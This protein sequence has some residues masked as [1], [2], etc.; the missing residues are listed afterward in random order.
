MKNSYFLFLLISLV[1]FSCQSPEPSNTTPESTDLQQL[2]KF[3]YPIDDLE[4]GMVYEY[5][6]EKTGSVVGYWHYSTVK[7]EAGNRYLIGTNYNPFFEQ[8]QFSREWIVATGTILK[9]YQFIQTDSATGKAIMRPAKIEESV[10]Y[11][12][13]ALSDSSLAYRFRMKFSLLPDTTTHYDLVRDRKFGKYMNY[14]YDGK[15]RKAVMF[16]TKEYIDAH[17]PVEGGS[18][19]LNS[20]MTEIFAAGIGLVYTKKTSQGVNYTHRLKRRFTMEEFIKMKES[21]IQN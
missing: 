11:P 18:W 2:K 3:Y 12:F 4:D 19:Q 20:D 21:T 15:E 5:V 6:D 8:D 13:E 17:N 10:V 16:N 7:D 9:D 14:T 1:L